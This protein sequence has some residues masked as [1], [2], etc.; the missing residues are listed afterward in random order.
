MRVTLAAAT[1]PTSPLA[2][3]PY[4]PSPSTTTPQYAHRV[5]EIPITSAAGSAALTAN[6]LIEVDGLIEVSLK[7]TT[8]PT[9]GGSGKLFIHTC[10]L[11]YQS[12]NM[13]TKNSAPNYY[14]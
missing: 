1:L 12:S 5:D 8:L 10:D 7:L 13:A 4:C 6:T 9:L 3:P 2:K 11:H 14:S